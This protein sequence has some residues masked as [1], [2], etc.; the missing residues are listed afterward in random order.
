MGFENKPPPEDDGCP[1][2][3]VPAVEAAVLGCEKSFGFFTGGIPA[4]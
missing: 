4:A 3:P 2:L 1:L